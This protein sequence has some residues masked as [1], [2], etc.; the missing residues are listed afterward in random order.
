MIREGF[1]LE[2]IP[3][4]LAEDKEKAE[5]GKMY[6]EQALEKNTPVAELERENV[7]RCLDSLWKGIEEEWSGIDKETKEVRDVPKNQYHIIQPSDIPIKHVGELLL[8]HNWQTNKETKWIDRED[9]RTVTRRYDRTCVP[10]LE[11]KETYERT[12]DGRLERIRD[13]SFEIS[14]TP[15]TRI[16]KK[17]FYKRILHNV[18]LD[19][20]A[21]EL[22]WMEDNNP[23]VKELL[24]RIETSK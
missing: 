2:G 22:K 7:L 9:H 18:S 24:A 8:G 11:L 21:G 1:P 20:S 17:E 13:N 5:L 3:E 16:E 23:F 19:H 12:G 4:K 14:Y 10:G 15:T 6:I